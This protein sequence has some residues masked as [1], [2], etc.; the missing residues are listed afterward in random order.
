MEIVKITIFLSLFFLAFS[1]RKV[2]LLPDKQNVKQDT[3]KPKDPNIK[4]KCDSTV[5]EIPDLPPVSP[6]PR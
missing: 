6:P 1:C 4:C 3:T 5:I 2:D